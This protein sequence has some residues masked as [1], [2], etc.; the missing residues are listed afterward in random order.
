MYVLICGAGMMGLELAKS[1]IHSSHTLAIVDTDPLACQYAREKIGIMAFEGS[2]VNTT[3]LLEAGIRKADAIIAALREDALNLAMVTLSKHYGVPQILVRMRN[4]DF[5]EPYRLAG[6]THII[7]TTE[8]AIS[9]V[10]S[11][12]E[13]PQ[14]DAMMHFEQG[15]VEVLKLR[16]PEKCSIVGR[17]LAELAQD[18]Q[19]PPGTLIIGYQAH[20]HEDL[21]IPN[22]NTVLENGSTILAVTKPDLL[23]QFL[24]FVS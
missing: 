20:T 12:I 14:V 5:D 24:D 23:H 18:P 9:R 7:S 16:I 4:P 10:V 2:A 1:L 11:A 15:K 22:G 21:I 13:Y 6:A 19:F 8:L 3:T 17:S